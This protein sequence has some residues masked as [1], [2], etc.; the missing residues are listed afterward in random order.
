VDQVS[1]RK[2]V[3]RCQKGT[4]SKDS[5]VEDLS[6]RITRIPA[7]RFLD[8]R[9]VVEANQVKVANGSSE[10]QIEK[11]TLLLLFGTASFIPSASSAHASLA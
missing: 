10:A 5:I 4:P 7:I 3:L 9:R 8:V 1:P 2:R 6:R 11:A